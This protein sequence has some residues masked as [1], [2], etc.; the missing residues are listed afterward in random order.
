MKTITVEEENWK[1][2]TYLKLQ[3]NL[4]TIDEVISKL[5]DSYCKLKEEKKP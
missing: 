4:T 3:E 1:K 5:L 2:L